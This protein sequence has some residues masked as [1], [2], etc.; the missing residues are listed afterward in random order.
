LLEDE[1]NT[2]EE[3]NFILFD[4]LRTITAKMKEQKSI[5][6]QLHSDQ[7]SSK[8]STE[9]KKQFEVIDLEKVAELNNE[10]INT[11]TVKNNIDFYS[12]PVMAIDTYTPEVV[13]IEDP[14]VVPIEPIMIVDEN[15]NDTQKGQDIQTSQVKPKRRIFTTYRVIRTP[16]EKKNLSVPVVD[17]SRL[18]EIFANKDENIKN[19]ILLNK[20]RH[21]TK[22]KS[23]QKKTVTQ[24]TLL[25]F[26]K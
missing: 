25:G 12:N 16:K 3:K 1:D 21:Y 15:I 23:L 20:K 7:K 24:T 19:D 13:I 17:Y 26:V 5:V 8:K 4:L 18:R 10:D 14:E 11:K 9:K 6:I 2:L 22:L